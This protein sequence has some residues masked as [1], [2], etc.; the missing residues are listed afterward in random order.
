MSLFTRNIYSTVPTP[1]RIFKH[2]S[3]SFVFKKYHNVNALCEY[4][5]EGKTYLATEE[6]LRM[7]FVGIT[8]QLCITFLYSKYVNYF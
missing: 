7:F 1:F 4:R 8:M 2:A 5:G 6:T 3:F